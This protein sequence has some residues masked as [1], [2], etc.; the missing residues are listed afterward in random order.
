MFSGVIINFYNYYLEKPKINQKTDKLVNFLNNK[1]NKIIKK[2]NI[3]ILVYESY[4]NLETLEYYGFD[5]TE[6]IN[7][8]EKNGFKVYHGIY[9][10]GS[11]S[12]ASTSRI[13][14]IDGNLS[15]HGRYYVSGNA[16]APEIFQA[17]GYKTIGL[18]KS[19]YFLSASSPIKWD[20]YHPFED[21]TKIGAK[22][23]TKAIF[24]G[25]FRFDIFDDF[26]NYDEYLELKN[27]Y[28]T[29]KKI[30][31]FFIHIMVILDILVTVVGVT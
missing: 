17:N 5:N 1:D 10:V 12:I 30:I 22:T 23:L 26:S 7:F 3:Y 19:S 31:R 24:Q 21:I 14:E 28:L 16:F 11:S 2:K 29:S 27:K 20:E 15:K 13:L 8:L 18:F 6:Q 4:S 25:E 9:S